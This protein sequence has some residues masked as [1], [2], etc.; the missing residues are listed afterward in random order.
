[1]TT[2]FDSLAKADAQKVES[3][4]KYEKATAPATSYKSSSGKTVTIDPKDKQ[5]ESLRKDLDQQKWVNRQQRESTFYSRYTTGPTYN[6]IHYSDPF[7]PALNYWLAS[8][9]IDVM[10]MFIYHHQNMDRARVDALYAQNAALR[11]RVAALES[12]KLARDPA[13]V[14]TG[15]DRDLM[16]DPAYVD[17]AY[18]PHPRMQTEYEYEDDDDG[19]TMTAGEFFGAIWFL[20]RWAF[21]IAVAI[22][23]VLGVLWCVRYFLF[24]KRWNI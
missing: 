15:I 4:Q 17:A 9:S 8:Q 18:N 16:Y 7:H 22:A 14:P 24:V 6:V 2:G 12:Q 5:I 13:W 1:M 20:I 19:P 23:V 3:R 21:Y 10:A 11:A